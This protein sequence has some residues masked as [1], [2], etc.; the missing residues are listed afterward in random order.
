MFLGAGEDAIDQFH[1]YEGHAFS[2]R[3]FG[4][5]RALQLPESRSCWRSRWGR[6]CAGNW[7]LLILCAN[8]GNRSKIGH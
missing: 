7:L 8:G 3:A 4:A 2:F 1:V 5:Q 6:C